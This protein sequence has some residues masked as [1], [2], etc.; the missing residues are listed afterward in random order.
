[1][2]PIRFGTYNLLDY[3]LDGVGERRER[4]SRVVRSLEADVLAVQEIVAADEQQAGLL[5]AELGEPAGLTCWWAHGLPAVARGHRLT[6]HDTCFYVGLLWNPARVRPVPGEFRAYSEDFWHALAAG[7]VEVDGVRLRVGSF[8]AT[9]FGRRM[10]ADQMERV[11]SVFTRPTGRPPGLIGADWNCVGADRHPDTGRLYD[12]DP[13]ADRPWIDDMIYQTTWTYDADGRRRH[14]ADREPGEVL[15]A[16]GL[17]DAAAALDAP[18]Q[19]TTGHWPGDPF[20]PRRIDAIRL[21]S[22]LAPALRQVE[23]IRTDL[24]LAASDHL[25]VI[26][27]LQVSAAPSPA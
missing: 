1:M 21:T 23:T 4:L 7:I 24:T 3:S 19:P 2:N 9:P 8:H 5:L 13:Y 26:A 17:R 25:P 15:Y 22:D 14:Q 6:G 12:R 20:G 18:W 11:V 10:R 27:T 16:G